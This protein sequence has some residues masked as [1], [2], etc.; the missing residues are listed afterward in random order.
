MLNLI[1]LLGPLAK[2]VASIFVSFAD[3]DI[4]VVQAQAAVETAAIG[5][6]ASVEQKW[7]FVA[8]MLPIFALPIAA[9][10]W[11]VVVWDKLFKLG[12]T[13]PLTGDIGNLAMI[14]VAGLFMHAVIK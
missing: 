4:A 13:D 12:V 5:A 9:W 2:A 14:I 6:T 1:S 11:K 3:K 7:W 10:E 8:A